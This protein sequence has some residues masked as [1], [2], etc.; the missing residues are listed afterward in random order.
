MNMISRTRRLLLASSGMAL[1]LA[2]LPR[3]SQSAN[4]RWDRY[5]RAVVIDG[6]G[7]PG[8]Y[9]TEDGFLLDPCE[10]LGLDNPTAAG[11]TSPFVPEAPPGVVS[12]V[13]CGSSKLVGYRNN[14]AYGLRSSSPAANAPSE[15]SISSHWRTSAARSCVFL[16]G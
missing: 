13:G 3:S 12:V 6:L 4:G 9:A 14:Q 15:P 7:G 8:S 1:G 11:V 10:I 5:P 16:N 2:V